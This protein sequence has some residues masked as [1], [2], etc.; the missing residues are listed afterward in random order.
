MTLES[1]ELLALVG[2]FF[3]TSL[4]SVVTGST[5]LI[6]V[7]VMLQFGI[8]PRA[9]VATNMFA[10]IFMSLGGSFS[11]YG[12]NVIE[13]DRLP[14]LIGLTLAGSVTG[15]ILLLVIP[16]GVV[17]FIISAFMIVVAFFSI[18]KMNTGVT[19]E[20]SE[21]SR[22]KEFLGFIMT[23]TL[24]IY[25][26]FF[27][28]GYVTFLTAVFV[29][30]FGMTFMRAISTTK[31]INIFSSLVATLIFMWHGLV[32]YR[33]GVLLGVTMFAG[34]FIG[35]RI[36]MKLSNIWLRRIFLAAVIILALK[37]IL[38]DPLLKFLTIS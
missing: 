9:A 11:F 16:S 36:A 31:M 29:A 18:T 17:P 14:A 13:S 27:S 35:G 23:F 24:G 37:L 33:L 32:D 2:I 30:F 28:G 12:K 25:G 34:A 20:D 10:L 6:T 38:Y 22:G 7:P 19:P 4:V 26:G 15:A 5:S 8:E 1:F 21:S 3:L